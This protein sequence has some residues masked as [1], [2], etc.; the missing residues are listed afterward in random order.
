MNNSTILLII[1]SFVIA[2][3]LA[4]FQYVYKA[5]KV[6][7][8]NAL[9]AL[10]FVSVFCALL[11]LIN[12]K[13]ESVTYFEEKPNLVIAIDNSE[14]VAYLNQNEKA[15]TLF[16]NLV[17][18]KDLQNKFNIE[19]FKFGD[20]VSTSDS[21]NF[22]DNTSNISKFFKNYNEL[23]SK[24]IAPIILISDG[25]QTIGN[26]YQYIASKSKQPIFPIILGDTTTFS[27]LRIS[28]VNANR[29]AYLKNKFPVEIIANYSGNQSVSSNL[30]IRSGNVV[31]FSK[32]LEFGPNKTSF[33]IN[34]NLNASSVGVKTYRVEISPLDN[35]KN[36]VNN[37]KNFAIEVIDQKTNIAL[38]AETIHPDLGAFKKA[39]ESNEQR[40]VE[41]LKPKEFIA[42]SKD[43]QLVMLYQ[44]NT[45]F[46]AVY[47][48]IIS[49]KLNTFTIAGSTTDF[50]FLNTN[51]NNF[52]QDITNQTENYQ[53]ILNVNYGT[54][55]VDN[56]TFENYPPLKSDFGAV[57]FKIPEET[58]LYKA[59]NGFNTEESLLSTLEAEER[60][61][62]LLN[63]EGIWRWRAQTYLDTDSFET[64]D[65]FIGKLIQYL[66]SNKKRRR[67]NLDYKSFYNQTENI[68]V[69][70]Q[71]F[72]KNYEFDAN[73]NLQITF[74]NKDTDVSKTLPLL[75]KNASYSIDL[76]SIAP[77]D[78]VFTV[79][80]NDEPV[81]ASGTF[82]VLEYNVE[83]QF[84]NADV[85]K[86]Q[87]I[88]NSSGGK[89]YF[90]EK[91]SSLIDD[92][93]N[94]KRFAT[95]QKSKR[96]TIPLIDYKYLLGLIALALSLE[97]FI[98]KY[99]GLI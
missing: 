96:N 91:S 26:D 6:A 40:S 15:K 99:K 30:T 27:D 43:F 53:P 8:R 71:F 2:L 72:N 16:Q 84:L 25:N 93:L 52:T 89:S 64:F 21:L 82:K 77:G 57:S 42:S 79:K 29:Y 67:L 49:Q 14:S 97:W 51:Q 90:I 70:A 33:I 39:I 12:P 11:L 46:K 74:R 63:G 95:I 9:I 36:K 20:D 73:A 7:S 32:R 66:S 45:A 59:V 56:I 44:P 61:H 86:L 68:I 75:L 19:T 54:F 62:A 48:K 41:I 69:N 13:F 35:E 18:N 24:S 78:Y 87:S 23:Y 94:D 28:Q 60:K 4:L 3:L 55:I 83:Q 38:I 10:R 65:N 85:S 37:Y 92:L 50:N 17:E 22:D 81:S 98:R 1:L 76:S 80:S 47:D 34:T 31:L 58:L 88:A 5:K